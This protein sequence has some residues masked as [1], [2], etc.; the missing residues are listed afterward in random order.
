MFLMSE[1]ATL[2]FLQ[3]DIPTVPSPKVHGSC[4]TSNNPTKT[5]YFIMD[6]VPG[7]SMWRAFREHEMGRERVFE[8]LRQ[9]AEVRKALPSRGW[10]E[11]G[12][13]TMLDEE[14]YVIEKQLTYRNFFDKPEEIESRHGLFDSS[15]S[16]YANLLQERWRKVQEEYLTYDEA[17]IQWKIHLYL[18][19][20][21]PSYVK[22]QAD[23]FFLAHTDLHPLNIFVDPQ[24]GSITGIIDW[25]FACTVPTQATEHFPLFLHKKFFMDH[26]NDV[27]DDPEAE[28]KEWRALYAKQFEGDTEME[29]YLQHIDAAIAFED[30]LKDHEL[31]TVENLVEKCKFLES[32]ETLDKIGIPLPWKSPT[33]QRPPSPSTERGSVNAAANEKLESSMETESVRSEQKTEQT[34]QATSPTTTGGDKQATI[35]RSPVIHTGHDEHPAN[36]SPT[37]KVEVAA[38]TDSISSASSITTDIHI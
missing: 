11:T 33:K 29:E 6:K 5:P 12:S 3:R 35:S 26:F 37:E 38:T 9:L 25:E 31:A 20:L 23:G 32:A 22:P 24:T 30:M 4:F 34:S 15:I 17:L 18:S 10:T 16:Y 13:F 1:Y 8:M 28:L 7:I 27:Y 2:Y 36:A 19:S 21:L 14:F